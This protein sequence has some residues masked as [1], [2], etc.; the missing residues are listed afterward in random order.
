M[1]LYGRGE[2]GATRAEISSRL[3]LPKMRNQLGTQLGRLQH[4]KSFIYRDKNQIYIT[5]SGEKFVEDN[6]LPKVA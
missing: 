2:K 5:R 3:F 1:L 6:L 4:D